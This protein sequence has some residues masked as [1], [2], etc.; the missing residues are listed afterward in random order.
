MFGFHYVGKQ[1]ERCQY[2]DWYVKLVLIVGLLSYTDFKDLR[3][4]L[5]SGCEHN[6]MLLLGDCAT[7]LHQPQVN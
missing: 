5:N 3:P 4:L 6:Q 7:Y 2:C 1:K